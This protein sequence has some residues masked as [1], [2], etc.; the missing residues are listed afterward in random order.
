MSCSTNEVNGILF[1][2]LQAARVHATLAKGL[3]AG[4]VLPL[5][6]T[7]FPVQQI[8]EA[9]RYLAKGA[10]NCSPATCMPPAL[11]YQPLLAYKHCFPACVSGSR[12]SIVQDFL[13][14]SYSL[15][16][17]LQQ[18]SQTVLTA[19]RFFCDSPL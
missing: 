7:I 18:A 6:F 5:P 11:T 12:P 1:P 13:F 19:L 2:F 14:V 8:E 16:L 17:Q 10:S 3:A 4:E 9:F 15:A